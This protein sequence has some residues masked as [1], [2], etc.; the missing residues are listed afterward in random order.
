MY[1]DPSRASTIRRVSDSTSAE[2]GASAAELGAGD[3]AGMPPRLALVGL[4]A[5]G[6]EG[7]ESTAFEGAPGRL[8]DALL[9]S[10]HLRRGDVLCDGVLDS[11]RPGNRDPRPD[12]LAA[13]VAALGERLAAAGADVVCA[14][15]RGTDAALRG[16][17][18]VAGPDSWPRPPQQIVL[19]G[20]AMHLVAL[21]HPA[22]AL[23]TPSLLPELERQMGLVP[24]LLASPLQQPSPEVVAGHSEGFSVIDD[25]MDDAPGAPA[26]PA[27]GQSDT[28]AADDEQPTLF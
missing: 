4:A 28:D 7:L 17:A 20:R 24:G 12:E 2:P 8:L 6:G 21:E 22:A 25:A 19:G 16:E 1:T 26:A 13:G 23:Y 15:G 9:A 11:P 27:G 18:D 5:G 3:V 10:A 14:L